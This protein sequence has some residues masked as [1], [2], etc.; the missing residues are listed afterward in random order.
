MCDLYVNFPSYPNINENVERWKHD[1]K[2]LEEEC[3]AFNGQYECAEKISNEIIRKLGKK[4]FS[5]VSDY[6]CG[7]FKQVLV[8]V[9]IVNDVFAFK[10]CWG[11]FFGLNKENKRVNIEIY[12]NIANL[13]EEKIVVL[14][15][16]I[17]EVISHEIMH[18][19]I[20]MNK[21]LN[22]GEFDDISDFYGKIV[23]IMN[24]SDTPEIVGLTRSFYLC[25]YQEAQAMVSQAWKECENKIKKWQYD[26]TLDNF[27]FVL[28]GNSI[29]KDYSKAL[30]F[31]KKLSTSPE[32][33]SV[34]FD[35][36]T[37]FGIVIPKERRKRILAQLCNKLEKTLRLIMKS[38]WC[39]F[40]KMQ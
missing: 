15:N 16:K 32:T 38:C 23:N 14:K 7:T 4:S 10:L 24:T 35:D 39:Y 6:D 9:N 37:Q 1:E 29:Y 2:I 20:T 19:Y 28:F 26:L 22:S 18:G 25:Y 34:I 33:I 5:I 40:N 3:H 17:S 11:N 8:K 27:K 12:V 31:C 21:L 13:T 36:L 30:R